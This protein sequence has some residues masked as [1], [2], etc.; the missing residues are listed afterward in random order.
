MTE[1]QINKPLKPKASAVWL[2]DNTSLSFEQIAE[3]TGLHVVEIQ[4]LADEE[5]G[6]GIIGESPIQCGELTNAE[7]ERCE[8]DAEASLNIKRR[9][10]PA[11][12]T[13]GKGPRYTPLAR[14]N[15]KPDAIAYLLKHHPDIPDAQVCKLIGTTKPTIQMV[16]DKSHANSSI[17]TPRHPC[18][19]GLCSYAEFENMIAKHRKASEIENTA[20]QSEAGAFTIQNQSENASPKPKNDLSNFDFSNFLKTNSSSNQ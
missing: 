12:K 5:V 3:Y 4:A 20:D 14:R 15:D 16:R 17:I 11:L 18:E 1:I 19:I 10:G 2:I 7:I 9:D 13:R 6:R 8:G